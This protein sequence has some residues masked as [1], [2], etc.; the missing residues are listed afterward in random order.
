MQDWKNETPYGQPTDWL[1]AGS[2]LK[3]KQP[4]S[5]SIMVGDYIRSAAV[6]VGILSPDDQGRFGFHNLRAF[7]AKT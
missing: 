4:R 2:R 5:A 7:Q 1:F 6:R 3:G